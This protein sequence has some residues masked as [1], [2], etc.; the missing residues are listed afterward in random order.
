MNI[1]SAELFRPY[2]HGTILFCT[3]IY[4]IYSTLD[5]NKDIMRNKVKYFAEVKICT[6][7][8]NP[9]DPQHIIAL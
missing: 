3:F 6:R 9:P 7:L 2:T 5:I 8:H 4:S 1:N